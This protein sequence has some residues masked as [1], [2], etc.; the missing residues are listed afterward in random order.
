MDESVIQFLGLLFAFL[1]WIVEMVM[2]RRRRRQM[3][4]PSSHGHARGD[5]LEPGPDAGGTEEESD[6]ASVRRPGAREQSIP[7]SVGE[8]SAASGQGGGPQGRARKLAGK[9]WRRRVRE[10]RRQDQ[11]RRG[12]D[13]LVGLSELSIALGSLQRS[14]SREVALA[15]SRLAS[16]LDS[17]ERQAEQRPDGADIERLGVALGAL[18]RAVAE[19]ERFSEARRGRSGKWLRISDE[20]ATAMAEG[21]LPSDS[22]PLLALAPGD[23]SRQVV[24]DA[25]GLTTVVVPVRWTDDLSRWP[26]TIERALRQILHRAPLGREIFERAG[27][28][29]I[30]SVD[31]FEPAYL[32]SAQVVGIFGPWLNAL[33]TDLIALVRLG[34]VWADQVERLVPGVSDRALAVQAAPSGLHI[35][36]E[37]PA[38]LRLC[39]MAEA[40]DGLGLGGR[41][42][43]L[44][45]RLAEFGEPEEVLLSFP[46]RRMVRYQVQARPFVQAA[47][48]LV[49]FLL[50]EP[51]DSLDGRSLAE[52]A[53]RSGWREADGLAGV[54]SSGDH[55]TNSD[56]PVR[57]AAALRAFAK[58]DFDER[59]AN[60]LAL[61][62][63]AG[64]GREQ[65]PGRNAQ[66]SEAPDSP[67]ETGR[68]DAPLVVESVVLGAVLGRHPWAR[69]GLHSCF[70]RQGVRRA[71]PAPGLRSGRL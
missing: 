63:L 35:D 52:L 64:L 23:A 14:H 30:W 50:S 20:F 58:S 11:R 18:Q 32:P 36:A 70:R 40:L 56:W 61:R 41:S 57:L 60:A 69:R 48:V 47:S 67:L 28:S 34:P 66:E 21:L 62:A 37:P 45:A 15:A 6:S 22:G 59:D 10:D 13:L 2:A 24:L 29:E 44:R 54:L 16:R 71:G 65:Q 17:I 25:V 9:I 43:S 5:G 42:R 68:I 38:Y 26:V 39:A 49:E 4:E 19:L 3:A 27:L 46:T 12:A 7:A 53:N 1:F 33:A 31:Y 8:H 51:F 55:L